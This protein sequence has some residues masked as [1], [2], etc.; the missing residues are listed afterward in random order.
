MVSDRDPSIAVYDAFANEWR[1][2]REPRGDDHRGDWVVARAVPDAPVADLGCG[3][4]W[5]LP[6]LGRDA[7]AVDASGPMLDHVRSYA[8][9]AH[10]VQ[11]DLRRLPFATASLGGALA[12]KSYVHLP[13]SE[14]PLAWADLH[15]VL[16][17]GSPLELV[18]FGDGRGVGVEHTTFDA[19]EF[20]GRR[21]SLWTE[22]LLET[23]LEGAG[24]ETVDL[25]VAPTRRGEPQ[26]VVLARRRRTL[27]D[28]VGPGMSVL[29][30]GLNP[31]LYAADAGVG[32][33]RPGNRFWPAAL[34]AGLVS[35]D[36]DAVHALEHHGVGTTDLVK[37]ATTKAAELSD[38]EFLHG[39]ARLERT[40]E[41]LK[42]AVVC[43]VGLTG[44]RAAVDP[45]ATAGIQDRTIGGSAVYVM[46]STS[47]AN[48]HT[49]PADLTEHFRRVRALAEQVS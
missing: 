5:H 33:A 27:A 7:I 12:S 6:K 10:P 48:A 30:C 39:F 47:G 15:R 18:V 44:W 14:V 3:P 29:T 45:H 24:F 37:R 17:P 8:E 2:R 9:A 40:V 13:R 38:D 35:V 28:T 26:F 19:D 22:D 4:G 43:F 34:A 16:R 11:A 21:F 32:Y 1:E 49:T 31:S 46:P 36:R 23:V 42:P 20:P 25:Q 41:W